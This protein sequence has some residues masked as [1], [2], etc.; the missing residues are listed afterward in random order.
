MRVLGT[1]ISFSPETPDGEGGPSL[2]A[3]PCTPG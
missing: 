3:D 2:T 1:N